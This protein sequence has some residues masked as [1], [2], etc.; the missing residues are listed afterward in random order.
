M[1]ET[2]RRAMLSMISPRKPHGRDET[3]SD[4][5][6]DKPKKTPREIF[7]ERFSNSDNEDETQGG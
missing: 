4:V 1:A 5:V 2:K 7:P 3:Q 6:N